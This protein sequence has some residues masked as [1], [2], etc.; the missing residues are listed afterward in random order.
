MTFEKDIFISYAHADNEALSLRNEDNGWVDDFHKSLEVR[1]K[2]LLGE[3]PKI[4]RDPKLQGNDYFGDEI[5][6]QLPNMALLVSILSPRYVNSKWCKREV[7]EFIEA[8]KQNVGDRIGNKSRVFKV[9]KTK[10]SR[11]RH[12]EELQGL[13]GYNFFKEDEKGNYIEFNKIFGEEA[14]IAY[15]SRLE[16]LAHDIVSLLQEIRTING[17]GAKVEE[18]PAVPQTSNG[19]VY[20]AETSYDLNEERDKVKRELTDNGYLVLPDRNL[21]DHLSTEYSASVRELLQQSD[22]SIHLF[23]KLYGKTPE[24]SSKS[25]VVLQNE[26]A[27]E[28]SKHG[29]L[30]RFIWIDP[31]V[32][33]DESSNS[34]DTRQPQFLDAL[35]G[36]SELQAGADIFESSISELKISLIDKLQSLQEKEDTGDESPESSPDQVQ[37]VYIVCDEADRKG[38]LVNPLKEYLFDEGFEPILPVFKGEEDAIREDHI[39]NLKN[40]HAVIIFHGEGDELWM[41]SKDRELKKVM[42]YGRGEPFKAKAIYLHDP[43]DYGD[44]EDFRSNDLMVINGLEGKPPKDVMQEFVQKLKES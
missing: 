39:E 38:R 18:T 7:E 3:K 36:S 1:L 27:A 15:W 16:D 35:R 32:D 9:I 5:S 17:N 30:E 4:W 8:A 34:E 37:Q 41:R 29:S 31:E 11:D 10:V 25:L 24:D 20:L 14:E 22:F 33:S 13:L 42:G 12:P 19:T 44:K 21:P 43:D 26:I 23:G 2:Q 6:G 40:C 28:Q